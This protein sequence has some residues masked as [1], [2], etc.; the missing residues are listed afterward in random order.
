MS[1]FSIILLWG[2]SQ[3]LPNTFIHTTP[4]GIVITTAEMLLN[5]GKVI[6]TKSHVW[7]PQSSSLS[8]YIRSNTKIREKCCEACNAP[9]SH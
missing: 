2:A 6:K 5:M 1:S 9:K 4:R 8:T 3:K 7:V